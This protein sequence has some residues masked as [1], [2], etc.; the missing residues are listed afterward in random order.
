MQ[1]LD[2][3]ESVTDGFTVYTPGPGWGRICPGRWIY[4]RVIAPR[5]LLHFCNII[6]Y[7]MSSPYIIQWGILGCGCEYY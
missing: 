4:S 2:A 6:S 1:K 3:E 5:F 7:T